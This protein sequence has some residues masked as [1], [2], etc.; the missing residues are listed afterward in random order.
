MHCQGECKN[1][2]ASSATTKTNETRDAAAAFERQRQRQ[3]ERLA[4]CSLQ[5]AFPQCAWE[6][7]L[8]AAAAMRIRPVRR[9]TAVQV[10]DQ[11]RQQQHLILG[12]YFLPNDAE[13]CVCCCRLCHNLTATAC[14]FSFSLSLCLSVSALL[15]RFR[16]NA[17]LEEKLR[18]QKSKLLISRSRPSCFHLLQARARHGQRQRERESRLFSALAIFILQLNVLWKFRHGLEKRSLATI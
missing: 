3:H 5:L 11:Q 12:F 7:F 8:R 16:R 9:S 14:G 18:R 10:I 15:L 4:A 17:K 13:M 1:S 2:N 6:S